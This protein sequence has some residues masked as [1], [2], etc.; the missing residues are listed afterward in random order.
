MALSADVQLPV[1]KGDFAD[2]P[3]LASMT[4]Y[5]GAV[6]SITAAGY[7]K[8]YAGTDTVFAGICDSK[9]DNSLGSSADIKVK[10][11]RDEHIRRV[12]LASVAIGDAGNAVYASDDATF[13]QT[14]GSNLRVGRIHA[15][16][17]A[18]TCYIKVEPERDL[19]AAGE[20]ATAQLAAG[21]GTLPKLDLTTGLKL[22][23]ADGINTGGGAAA[24]TLTG[25]AVGDRV[26]G[27]FGQ[28]KA[29]SGANS[30][31][32]PTLTT[33][34]EAV[35]T[36]VDEIQQTVAAGDLSGNTYLFILAPA[37]A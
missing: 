31:L 2:Q 20:I 16:I 24:I 12:T 14:K 29:E 25:A 9:A 17:A 3:V 26:V 8:G 7:A 11:R 21:A 33:H 15:Y 28:I 6:V 35:I 27:I 36:V 30:F 32:I 4:I 19:I 1:L 10:I 37:A 34:H 22:L 23:A 18:N 13:T 5:E